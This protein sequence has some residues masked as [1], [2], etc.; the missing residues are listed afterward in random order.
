MRIAQSCLLVLICLFSLSLFA[1]KEDW[2]PITQ[3]DLEIKQVPDNP[4]ADAV[5]LYYANYID[6][7]VGSE[8]VYHRIKILTES[9]KKYADVEITA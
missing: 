4:G 8:F 6:D 7:S 1:Q 5:Q 9:G 2:Q 3:Q